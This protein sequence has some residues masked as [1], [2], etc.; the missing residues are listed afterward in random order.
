MQLVVLADASQKAELLE[1]VSP[2]ASIVWVDEISDFLH[3]QEADAFV[4][5]LFVN[6]EG[7][8]VLLMRLL[9]KPIIINSVMDTLEE[10]NTSF[11]RINGWNTFLSSPL[12]EATASKESNKPKV[13]AVFSVF[14]KKI[15][16]VRDDPGFITARIVSM[17]INEAYMALSESVSTKDEINTAMKLG[18]AYPYGPFKWA[19]KIGV[20]S[21]VALLEKLSKT[22][23][24]YKP[25]EL[26]GQEAA[27]G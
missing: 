1:A 20:K 7:R 2:Q 8:K 10:T 23:S 6:E 12:V 26:L 22:N 13:E 24:R 3:H 25:A 21:I 5:L 18:T 11:V 17:I 4:D 27:E 19:E 14:D 9:P 15:E 16:W